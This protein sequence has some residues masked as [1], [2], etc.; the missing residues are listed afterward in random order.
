M[1]LLELGIAG[2]VGHLRGQAV[3]KCDL[4]ENPEIPPLEQFTKQAGVLSR[5]FSQKSA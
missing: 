2:G 1:R 4:S 3:K 5:L